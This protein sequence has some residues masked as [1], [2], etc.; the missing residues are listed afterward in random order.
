MRNATSSKTGKRQPP[1]E[2]LREM[3]TLA[4]QRGGRCVSAKYTNAQTKLHWTCAKGH[5]WQAKPNNISNGSWCPFCARARITE[6]SRR[7]ID[8]LR[9]YAVSRG[10][11]CLASDLA[12]PTT[13]VRWRCE[14]GHEWAASPQSALGTRAW[15]RECAKSRLAKLRAETR[16]GLLQKLN[17]L[18]ATRGG[19]CISE[20][21]VGSLKRLR[22]RC[23]NGHEW[24]ASAGDIRRGGWC[25]ACSARIGERICR[26]FFEQLFDAPFPKVKPKWLTSATG[27]LL[28]LDGYN[29]ALGIAFEHQGAF[30]YKN[31]HPFTPTAAALAARKRA[32]AAKRRICEKRGVMLIE[33]PEIP[34]LTKIEDVK[35]YILEACRRRGVKATKRQLETEV[36]LSK[37]Y[38]PVQLRHLLDT[39]AKLRGGCLVSR[40]FLG[41]SRPLSW[42]CKLGHEWKAS[43]GSVFYQKTWCP[44]CAKNSAKTLGDMKQLALERGGD[45]LSIAYLGARKPLSWRCALG[46]EWRATPTSLISSKSWCPYCAGQRGS[47]FTIQFMESTAKSRGGQCLSRAYENSKTRLRW[48]CGNGHEWDAIP[49]NV[50]N[51]GSWCPICARTKSHV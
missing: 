13:K 4:E 9:Q 46:H 50:V 14:A 15:C 10:G 49:L 26:E 32:D 35:N 27:T 29:E 6:A 11:E 19:A 24:D 30:H 16:V 22:W 43:A 20:N 34:A 28:E 31:V 18:A 45:C 36:D 12:T 8:D 42:S 51:K 21:T 47:K 1:E 7:T 39:Q 17:A 33:V 44:L 3:Q 48:R 25:P 37:A 23:G 40:E 5:T 38:Q 2:W 41:W